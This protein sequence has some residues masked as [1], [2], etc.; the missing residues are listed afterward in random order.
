MLENWYIEHGQLQLLQLFINQLS[1]RR[2]KRVW[3]AEVNNDTLF[4]VFKSHVIEM[5]IVTI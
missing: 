3:F 1:Y 5:K 2:I 4:T